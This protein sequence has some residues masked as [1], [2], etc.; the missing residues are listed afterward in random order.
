[1]TCIAWDGKTL[2]ADK[3]ATLS[4]Q[5]RTTTKIFRLPDGSLIGVAGNTTE[6]FDMVE[7]A[8]NGFKPEDFPQNQ[9]DKDMYVDCLHVR[10]DGTAWMY[11]RSPAPMRV[12]DLQHAIGSGRDYALMAMHLGKTAREAV[13]L[14]G[15]FDHNCGNGIDELDLC[16][17]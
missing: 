1:M 16:P 5:Y 13:E 6:G 9:R 17:G 2:A 4:C 8:R 12:E 14:A 3:R 15:R 11:Q 7:W 10:V